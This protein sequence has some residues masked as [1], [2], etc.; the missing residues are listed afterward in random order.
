MMLLEDDQHL[1]I[2]CLLERLVSYLTSALYKQNIKQ[3]R[4]GVYF[5]IF[6]TVSVKTMG[7]MTNRD[8]REW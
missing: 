4:T 7:L 2:K 6:I 5:F 3:N 8:A 1:K